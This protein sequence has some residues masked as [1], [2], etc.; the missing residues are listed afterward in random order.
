[1]SQYFFNSSGDTWR[2][3]LTGLEAMGFNER[4]SV[5]REAVAKFGKDGL[6]HERD[7]R[8]VQLSKLERKSDASFEALDDRYCRSKEVIDVLAKRYVLKNPD[9]FK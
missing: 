7:Q 4:L 1:M 6:S 9:E 5:L 3:V 2:D 8:M